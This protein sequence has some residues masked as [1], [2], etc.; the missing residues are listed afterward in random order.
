MQNVPYQSFFMTNCGVRQGDNLS[1]VLFL[2]FLNDLE[3]HL[4]SD[5]LDGIKIEC[6]TCTSV[7]KTR[8]HIYLNEML[9]DWSKKCWLT[10]C[11]QIINQYWLI[12][13]I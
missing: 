12:F 4:L 5:R 6:N 1:P 3:Y 2:M 7:L 9:N 10:Q 11:K 13:V 8:E